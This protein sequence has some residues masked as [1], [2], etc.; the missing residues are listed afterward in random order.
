MHQHDILN[1]H[2]VQELAFSNL[3]MYINPPA[4]CT[5]LQT[6]AHTLTHQTTSQTHKLRNSYTYVHTP[7]FKNLLQLHSNARTVIQFKHTLVALP[8]T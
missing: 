1:A 2:I 4:V 5:H 7:K 3:H 8:K 6:T